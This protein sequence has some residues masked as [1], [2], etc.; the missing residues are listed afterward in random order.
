VN[1]P[2]VFSYYNEYKLYRNT[3]GFLKDYDDFGKSPRTPCISCGNCKPRC[4]Q[5]ID[6]PKWIEDIATERKTVTLP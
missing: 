2:E 5:G 6:I 3:F 1:I 4:P